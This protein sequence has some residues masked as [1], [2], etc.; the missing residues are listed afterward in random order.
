MAADEY[1][2][3]VD[4]EDEEAVQAVI[5]INLNTSPS[6]TAGMAAVLACSKANSSLLII[7]AENAIPR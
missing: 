2:I 4:D 1:V 3:I 5:K 6:A 7:I